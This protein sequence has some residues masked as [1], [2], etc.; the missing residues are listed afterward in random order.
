MIDQLLYRHWNSWKDGKW[1]HL[2]VV[3]ADGGEP[4]DL[5]TRLD[6]DFPPFPWGGSQ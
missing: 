5:T 6:A 2:F 1:N 4:R 3:D